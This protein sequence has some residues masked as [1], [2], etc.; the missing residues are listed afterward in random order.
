MLSVLL[1]QFTEK[2]FKKT[3]NSELFLFMLVQLA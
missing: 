1:P 3:E 2:D